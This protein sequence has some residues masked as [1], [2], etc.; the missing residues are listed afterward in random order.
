MNTSS[1]ITK[2]TILVFLTGAALNAH[3]NDGSPSKPTPV[4]HF[5]PAAIPD[6]V[7]NATSTV[8]AK[9]KTTGEVLQQVPAAAT[10]TQTQAKVAD[11]T[12]KQVPKS[13]KQAAPVPVTAVQVKPIRVITPKVVKP[14]IK[15]LH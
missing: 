9:E 7:P 12:V 3:A 1:L 8:P 14:V 2:W 11:E 4:V 13:K 15:V 6:T 5:L 10:A